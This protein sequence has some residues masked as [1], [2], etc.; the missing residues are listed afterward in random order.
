MDIPPETL[1]VL[2]AGI[3]VVAVLYSCVGHAGAS[4]YIAV[5]SLVG[6]APTVIKP[7]SLVLNILV[8]TIGAI[9]FYRAGHF[10]WRLY[11]PFAVLDVP[12]AFMGGFTNL[13]ARPFKIVVGCVLLYSALM[14]ILQRPQDDC[15]RKPHPFVAVTLGGVIGLLS[16]LTGTG[17]G[18]FLTP[19]LLSCRW[20]TTKTAAGVS[21]L[22]IL[23]N[24]IAG[25]AGNLSS[26]RQFPAFA[27][28]L[29]AAAGLGGLVG[30]YLGSRQFQ[31]V[32]ITRALAAVLILA[33]VKL[34]LT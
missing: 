16:G 1:A 13:P 17:G 6:I 7:L 30:S 27:F 21:A 19:L 14:L 29:V 33:G 32:M 2:T 34:I 18:I 28:V 4:G 10:N 8:A 23:I 31:P 25:L 5:M 22:F 24:S 26:T 11:W 20:A 12:M 9:Q 3:F 15:G